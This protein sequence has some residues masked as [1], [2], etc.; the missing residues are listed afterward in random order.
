MAT[1][2]TYA[3][4][5]NTAVRAFLTSVGEHYLNERFDTGNGTGKRRWDV[6]KEKFGNKCAYCN[7][8]GKLQIEHLVMFNRTEYGLHHPGNVVPCC[9]ECNKRERRVVEDKESGKKKKAYVSWKEQLRIIC[10]NDSDAFREREAKITKSI[11][12]NMYPELTKN[13]QNSIR[14]MAEFLYERIKQTGDNATKL[15]S[16]LDKSF[17]KNKD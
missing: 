16:E 11:R 8:G 6:I 14:V 9:S 10:K 15:Y 5:A 4:A 2:N 1:H 12:D 17:V 7:T 3:D 13:E